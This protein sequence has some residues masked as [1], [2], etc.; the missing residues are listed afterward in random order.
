MYNRAF[1][2]GNALFFFAGGMMILLCL[3]LC[4]SFIVQHFFKLCQISTT[5]SSALLCACVS[6]CA[7]TGDAAKDNEVGH[8]GAA[9]TVCA[10]DAAGHFTGCKQA[11][12]G[13]ADDPAHAPFLCIALFL[14]RP[15]S[16][17]DLKLLL[18]ISFQLWYIHHTKISP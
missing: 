16:F 1:P 14:W 12:D 9:Q 15:R 10:V 18:A 4:D 6:G 2:V 8:S 5:G 11:G 7:V 13:V 17:S 3:P